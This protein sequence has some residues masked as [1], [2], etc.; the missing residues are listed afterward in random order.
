MEGKVKTLPFLFFT[1][2]EG[3]RKMSQGYEQTFDELTG[4]L[5]GLTKKIVVKVLNSN[6]ADKLKTT[7]NNS[8]TENVNGAIKT[9]IDIAVQKATNSIRWKIG[10]ILTI[11]AAIPSGLALIVTLASN[12][13]LIIPAVIFAFL[14]IIIWSVTGKI[15]KGIA[16]KIS[17]KIFKEIEGKISKFRN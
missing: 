8:S 13:N 1:K 6:F 9:L 7:L 10:I 4:N 17:S 3:D 16:N 5:T 15:F 2:N 14:T 11:L 12:G